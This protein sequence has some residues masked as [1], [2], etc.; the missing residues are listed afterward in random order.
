VKTFAK[1]FAWVSFIVALTITITLAGV[2]K[3]FDVRADLFGE[4]LLVLL[5]KQS[6]E[7]AEGG[8]CAILSAREMKRIEHVIR[9]T[10][11]AKC[12]ASR[13]FDS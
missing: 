5:D 6:K 10:E 12:S 3:I 13:R 4:G 8:G 9:S 7:C 11:A 2:C 1:Q